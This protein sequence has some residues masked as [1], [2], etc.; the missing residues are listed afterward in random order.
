MVQE[1]HDL[2]SVMKDIHIMATVTP[3]RMRRIAK[4]SGRTLS[5]LGDPQ[6]L[7]AGRHLCRILASSR[8]ICPSRC[9]AGTGDGNPTGD[10][11]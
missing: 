3:R 5:V 8:A 6:A 7:P 11:R 4:V 10:R 1:L 9:V 2:L